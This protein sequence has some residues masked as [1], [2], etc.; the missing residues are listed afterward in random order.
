[1]QKIHLRSHMV[2][3]L[4]PPREGHAY[5]VTIYALIRGCDALLL[6]TGFEEHG[7]AVRRDLEAQGITPR[8]A[9]I[10]HFH[11][12]HT[13]GLR[14]LPGVEIWGS[15][16][17]VETLRRYNTPEEQRAYAPT[18]CFDQDAT[19]AF[20][21]FTL[22]LLLVPG[23]AVCNV[24]TLVDD[25]FLH[26]GD[27]I[28]LSNEGN[29]LLPWVELERLPE[30]IASLDMLRTYAHKTLLLSHGPA[31]S[32]VM[33]VL[34]DLD[35]RSAYLRAVHGA[36]PERLSFEQ[37]TAGCVGTFSPREWHDTLYD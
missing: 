36:L 29:P 1:M 12:D 18:R 4:F 23:H 3:Y 9:L 5:G 17:A 10:S 28:M 2:Q 15:A 37:A 32:G 6:D 14:S 33:A 24:F 31:L 16:R 25:G 21:P 35:D 27:D 34:R 20:G 13:G 30:H 22:R 26:V 11:D 7:A 8:I 19:V